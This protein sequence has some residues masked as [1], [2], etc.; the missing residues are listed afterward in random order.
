M[1]VWSNPDICN[2]IKVEGSHPQKNWLHERK[3]IGG[4][5]LDLTVTLK[6]GVEEGKDD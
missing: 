5:A 4:K 6:A 1:S 3:G 2:S